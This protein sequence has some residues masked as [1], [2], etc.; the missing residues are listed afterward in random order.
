MRWSIIRLVWLRELRDQLRDRR[1]LFMVL[2]LPILL[3]PALGFAVLKFARGFS[4]RPNI[5]G[6]ARGPGESFPVRTPPGAGLSV[7]PGLAGLTAIGNPYGAAGM[8]LAGHALLDYPQLVRGGKFATFATR[9][10]LE[11]AT[12]LVAQMQVRIHWLDK[13]DTEALK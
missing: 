2:V 11:Q 8:A 6:I 9:T 12:V 5:V 3:Y 10:P 7:V 1:T 13:A 4:E